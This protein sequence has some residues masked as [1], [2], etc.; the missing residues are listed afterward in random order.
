MCIR[1]SCVCCLWS[2]SDS[3]FFFIRCQNHYNPSFFCRNAGFVSAH[4]VFTQSDINY[5]LN[6]Q[7]STRMFEMKPNISAVVWLDYQ[8]RL[9][10]S[11]THMQLVPRHPHLT[12]H[13]LGVGARS[14]L[15]SSSV[16]ACAC[17]GTGSANSSATLLVR[18]LY[19]LRISQQF[20]KICCNQHSWTFTVSY[21]NYPKMF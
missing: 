12:V 18:P 7:N 8:H 21:I 2:K 11:N 15:F 16:C 9:T 17:I 10:N 3:N 13:R 5:T 1:D 6:F 4:N 20:H 19:S 14:K